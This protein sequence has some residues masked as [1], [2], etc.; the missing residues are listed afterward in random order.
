MP[1]VAT[2]ISSEVCNTLTL[3]LKQTFFFSSDPLRVRKVKI[4]QKKGSG[5]RVSS[6]SHLNW[7]KTR[8]C[9]KCSFH[10]RIYPLKLYQLN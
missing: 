7:E 2:K 9:L 3:L 8:N 1:K 6:V 10:I 5:E 4:M